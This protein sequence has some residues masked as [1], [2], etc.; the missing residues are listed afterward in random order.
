MNNGVRLL[1]VITS[2]WLRDDGR[3][4]YQAFHPRINDGGMLSCYIMDDEV[5]PKRVLDAF[6][7]NPNR[8]PPFGILAFTEEELG[9]L[10]LSIVRYP[11]STKHIGHAHV[12]VDFSNLKPGTQKVKIAE[13]LGEIAL[14]RGW[15]YIHPYYRRRHH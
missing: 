12:H 2:Q 11:T 14:A 10:G 9:S 8:R 1:R 5:Q 7:R 4:S 3:L 6:A 15:L 13:S